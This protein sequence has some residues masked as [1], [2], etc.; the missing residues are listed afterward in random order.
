MIAVVVNRSEDKPAYDSEF[1]P[2]GNS[3]ERDSNYIATI[4]Q[5]SVPYSDPYQIVTMGRK[6]CQQLVVRLSFG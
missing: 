5:W 3:S 4:Q 2:E 1:F 6:A